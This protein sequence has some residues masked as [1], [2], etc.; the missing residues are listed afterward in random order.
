MTPEVRTALNKVNAALMELADA[1]EHRDEE[2]E[3]RMYELTN[4]IF[5]VENKHN[6]ALKNIA[7]SILNDLEN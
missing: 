4:H 7:H 6:T 2:I 3:G 5:T 1:L